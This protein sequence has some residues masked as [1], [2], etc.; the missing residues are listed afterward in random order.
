MIRLIEAHNFRS[1]RHISEPVCAF[2]VLVGPNA[3]GK[4]T[5]L[6]SLAFLRDLVD[7]G[8]EQA[9]TKRSRN[10]HDLVWKR[11]AARLELAI[12]A[13]IPEQ[14][15]TPR[16]SPIY[17]TVRYEIALGVHEKTNKFGILSQA[18]LLRNAQTSPPLTNGNGGKGATIFVSPSDKS[19]KRLLI[20]AP[21][22]SDEFRAEPEEP[23]G[24]LRDEDDESSEMV[25]D[26][27]YVMKRDPQRTTFAQLSEDEFPASAW[28]GRL[29]K[30]QVRSIDLASRSLRNPSPPGRGFHLLEDGTNLPQVI[31]HLR[32][33]SPTRYQQW[34]SHVK[35]ALPQ[36]DA[37]QIVERPED[38]H[39][40]IAI[41][42]GQGFTVP[43]WMLSDGTLRL[44]ALTA[45]PYASE[46]G[47]VYLIE[48][49]ETSLHPLNI[50]VVMQSLGST[51]GSQVFVT[52]Q[53]PLVVAAAELRNI[54]VFSQ[55]S[56]FETQLVRGDKHP[57]LQQWKG[58]PHLDVLFA[59]GVLG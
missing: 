21:S 58:M 51:Y 27:V 8:V 53:A 2:Q 18:L 26:Y 36:V 25:Y 11:R 20:D 16:E 31:E 22:G 15:R 30:S 13:I 19:W 55:N 41:R 17:D 38:K 23:E 7:G 40:Y 56:K 42:Y 24:F 14:F 48:E 6:D 44:L 35:T 29:L 49:P 47:T 43:S 9:I 34:Y 32:D 59:S 50:D 33:T 4:S 12:E 46:D 5:F 3:S 28:L 45:I 52:T 57:S 39:K 10:Y 54:L 1:L 37:I